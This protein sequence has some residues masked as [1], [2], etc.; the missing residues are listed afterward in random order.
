[1]TSDRIEHPT[2]ST[3]FHPEQ[4]GTS[5]IPQRFT[6]VLISVLGLQAPVW[7]RAADPAPTEAPAGFDTPTLITAP[8]SKSSSNGIVQPAGD[9]FA[10]DQQIYET[11]HDVTTGL[12]PV[13]NA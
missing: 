4:A 9:T 5:A 1:M 11:Q 3:Q 7:A 13:C 2:L 8:G 12:G 10:F 6:T